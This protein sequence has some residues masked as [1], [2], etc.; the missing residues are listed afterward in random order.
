MLRYNKSIN[1]LIEKKWWI[2]DALILT[3]LA[4]LNRKTTHKMVEGVGRRKFQSLLS[5]KILFR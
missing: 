4:F 2:L 5:V 1:K 3:N